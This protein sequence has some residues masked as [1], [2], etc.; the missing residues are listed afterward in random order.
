MRQ[1]AKSALDKF[2]TNPSLLPDNIT[3]D[4]IH[5]LIHLSLDNSYFEY[6]TFYKQVTGGPMGSPLTV[7]L[8]EIR[9]TDIE[10]LAISSFSSPPKQYKHFVDDGFGHFT[11]PRRQVSPTHKQSNR[12]PPIHYRIPLRRWLHPLPRR[13]YSS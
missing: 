3:I 7:A 2:R 11:D 12:R 5:T 10:N 4:A 13:S 6:N 9:V 8:A 1:S